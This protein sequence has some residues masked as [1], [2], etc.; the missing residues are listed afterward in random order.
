M[1]SSSMGMGE[2]DRTERQKFE[3]ELMRILRASN[4]AGIIMRVIGSLAFQMHCPKFGYLQAS[5]GRAYTDIDFAAYHRQFKEN[6]I[7]MSGLGYKENR[8]VFIVST[9]E[10]AIFDRAEIGVHLDIFYEKLAF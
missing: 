10:R 7:L 9:G 3:N 6:Q 4:D 1:F 8:E 2:Q 5:M